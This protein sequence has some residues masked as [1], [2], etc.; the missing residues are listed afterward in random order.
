MLSNPLLDLLPATEDHPPVCF[1]PE[2]RRFWSRCPCNCTVGKHQSQKQMQIYSYTQAQKHSFS[3]PFTAA[4][5]N[6][7]HFLSIHCFVGQ[8]SY[9]PLSATKDGIETQTLRKY[10]YIYIYIYM[11]CPIV[12][13]KKDYCG[14]FNSAI[15]FVEEM[16]A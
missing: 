6:V 14:T 9:I 12:N 16:A 7:R 4:F 15:H 11:P 8:A 2:A 5:A 1:L 3:I 10:I 13:V